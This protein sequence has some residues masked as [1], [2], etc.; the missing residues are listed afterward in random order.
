MRRISKKLSLEQFTSRLPSLVPYYKD[1][2]LWY[3]TP[4]GGVIGNA[5][6]R[7][8]ANYGGIPLLVEYN[9]VRYSHYNMAKAYHFF[10]K[11]YELINNGPC[12]RPY[13]SATA[14][15][16]A[17]VKNGNRAD[18]EELD[19]R[20][21]A[22]QGHVNPDVVSGKVGDNISV[23]YY[24][25]DGFYKEICEKYIPTFSIPLQYTNDPYKW[26]QHYLYYPDA[27]RWYG[28]FNAVEA[29]NPDI[30]GFKTIDACSAATNC[31]LC[32]EY[33]RRGG[34]EMQEKLSGWIQTIDENLSELNRCYNAAYDAYNERWYHD[35][36]DVCFEKNGIEETF[37]GHINHDIRP[38][39]ELEVY[40]G[41]HNEDLGQFSVLSEEWEPGVDYLKSNRKEDGQSGTVV[42][43]DN[44]LYIKTGNGLGY[45]Y[46]KEFLEMYWDTKDENGRDV[47]LEYPQIW[48][49]GVDSGHSY[50]ACVCENDECHAEHILP[51]NS[52]YVPSNFTS[53]TIDSLDRVEYNPDGNL[54]KIA[55]P[56]DIHRWPNGAFVINGH[57]YEIQ[58]GETVQYIN[59]RNYDVQRNSFGIPTVAIGSK[60][61]IA[62]R[63]RGESNYSFYFK[64]QGCNLGTLSQVSGYTYIVF[65]GRRAV[66]KGTGGNS[67]TIGGVT[68][69]KLDGYTNVEGETIYVSGTSLVNNDPPTYSE[70]KND[71]WLKKGAYTKGYK[72]ADGTLF[73]LY[74]YK[75]YYKDRITGVTQ[76]KL[77][78]LM[79]TDVKLDNIG[80]P[81]H[82]L[83]NQ[84]RNS[85]SNSLDHPAFPYP[86][87]GETLDIFYQ[88]GNMSGLQKIEDTSE[89]DELDITYIGN[90]ITDMVFYMTEKG[91]NNII[92]AIT[93]AATSIDNEDN[94]RCSLSAITR[95]V[96]SCNAQKD[97][98]INNQGIVPNDFI[99]CDITYKY[100][101]TIHERHTENGDNYVYEEA[102]VVDDDANVTYR[103]HVRLV[104]KSSFYHISGQKSYPI[105]YYD[106]ER[107]LEDVIDD[108]GN[109]VHVAK[110][111][112]ECPTSPDPGTL[113]FP[114]TKKEYLLGATSLEK[115][116]GSIY[117]DRGNSAAIEKHLKL[118]EVC[119]FEDLEQYGNGS[120][121]MIKDE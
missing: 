56:Y 99:D 41:Q 82:G 112:F 85:S 6:D 16:D 83:F 32:E 88:V 58:S 30:K 104:L 23:M 34:H 43:H 36:D 12:M 21:E 116:T 119:S 37:C 27:F 17:E 120:I 96:D 84:H 46:D 29:A 62:I 75:T 66:V 59:D 86:V 71:T 73:V 107:D 89:D 2:E 52:G 33:V 39:I 78:S 5:D 48:L 81:L 19:R 111:G 65:D 97:D 98:L 90:I 31:C 106:V 115:V 64:K 110:C 45:R 42:Y 9:N 47:W 22:Y 11:Y 24:V 92:T 40:L 26:S 114:L 1:G 44:Q 51:P 109:V 91:T 55:T 63:P 70:Y 103:E 79:S 50:S 74:P 95:V 53:Y 118:G 13:S 93:S 80:S 14:Y 49:E 60:K 76:S 38:Y 7:A 68:Y 54:D 28:W 4:C 10:K 35:Y 20:F 113:P 67:I 57:V 77:E 8:M 25:D 102:P 87:E 101:A 94:G 121:K 69:Q 3:V 18:Y 108:D 72:I 15:F 61:F 117:V 100:G 105:R